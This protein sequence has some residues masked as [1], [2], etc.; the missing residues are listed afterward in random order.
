MVVHLG[1]LAFARTK[2]LDDNSDKIFRDVDG[3]VLDRFHELAIDPTCDN[4]RFANHQFI[5]LAAH[6]L[7]QDRELQLTS[8]H[9]FEVVRV[10]RLFHF[11]ADICQQLFL[12]A[13]A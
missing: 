4:L 12:Q 10:S 2:L 8:A 7:D 1:H 6:G 5:A 11:K 13:L 9:Y 3:Q